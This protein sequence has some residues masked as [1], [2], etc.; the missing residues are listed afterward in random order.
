[1]TQALALDDAGSIPSLRTQLAQAPTALAKL[2]VAKS[3]LA[4]REETAKPAALVANDVAVPLEPLLVEWT[5][6]FTSSIPPEFRT[7]PRRNQH[8]LFSTGVDLGMMQLTATATFEGEKS[9]GAGRAADDLAKIKAC[10][11]AGYK[12][13]RVKMAGLNI[14]GFVFVKDG[15][16]VTPEGAAKLAGLEAPAPAV[17]K[18]RVTKAEAREAYDTLSYLLTSYQQQHDAELLRVDF[19]ERLLPLVES[20]KELAQRGWPEGVSDPQYLFEKAESTIARQDRLKAEGL[21]KDM[22]RGEARDYLRNNGLSPERIEA[23]VANP[24]SV[25]TSGMHEVPQ[26]TMAY[27][28]QS[29]AEAKNQVAKVDPYEEARAKQGKF[30][31]RAGAI[32]EALKAAGMVRGT[33]HNADTHSRGDARVIQ[34]SGSIDIQ[35]DLKLEAMAF[36]TYK[37]KF[38]GSSDVEI[39]DDLSVSPE[40]T[41]AKILQE[42]DRLAPP[43]P[44]S[45]PAPAA[46]ADND[47][48]RLNALKRLAP[49]GAIT[50]DDPQALEKLRA[51]LAAL[52]AEQEFMKKANKL[53]KAGNDKGLIEMGLNQV[54]IE[55]LKKPDFAGRIGFADYMLS[56]NNGVIGTTRKRIAELEQK[57]GQ[58]AAP[59]VIKQ[60]RHQETRFVIK[61][62]I[63]GSSV[64]WRAKQ[65]DSW[66]L[67]TTYD[68][69]D[70][71]KASAGSQGY[72]ADSIPVYASEW[73]PMTKKFSAAIPFGSDGGDQATPEPGQPQATEVAPTEDQA[74]LQSIIDGTIDLLD[75]GIFDK[76]EPMFTKYADD[77]EMMGMLNRAAEAYTAAAVAAAK[78]V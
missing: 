29:I 60:A 34:S 57:A 10:E 35:K 22:G 67:L 52:M 53:I 70:L 73:N 17:S 16:A 64:E 26:Y 27:L 25:R 13:Q 43:A 31:I 56:N 76:L 28:N 58:G 18:A 44:P 9:S 61:T 63:V 37:V 11:A 7:L 20:V 40:E 42:V 45:Q 39:E 49:K 68:T 38:P 15:L 19:S 41:A 1:M 59:A 74:Y 6:R 69:L 62:D 4:A 36:L 12:R 23:V 32:S 46:P 14:L 65:G 75:P 33:D 30:N 77:A 8:L 48:T 51:K 71:A 55:G 66:V 47:L 24:T 3:I 78:G 21:T 50:S 2:D 5:P 54:T 72:D